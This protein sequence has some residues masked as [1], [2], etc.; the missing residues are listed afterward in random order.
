[1]FPQPGLQGG[2]FPVRQQVH[3]GA[4]ADVYQH[5]AVDLAL[6]QREVVDLSGVHF[7][8]SVTS[9]SVA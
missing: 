4:G 2:R 6:A 5:G 7:R 9:V 8:P 1:M 3:H